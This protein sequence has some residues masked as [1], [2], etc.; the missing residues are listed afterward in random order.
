MDD[1]IAQYANYMTAERDR[2][3][4]TVERYQVVL[5]SFNRFLAAEIDPSTL[6]KANSEHVRGFIRQKAVEAEGLTPGSRNVAISALRSFYG[7][8]YREGRIEQDPSDRLERA[9][10][11]T[12]EVVPLSFNEY[13]AMLEAIEQKGQAAYRVRNLA[14]A[15]TLFHTGMRVAELVSLDLEDVDNGNYLFANVRVKG[16]NTL[17]M[18]YNDVVAEYIERWLR[19]RPYLHPKET[20]QA[21]FVSD[22]GTRITAQAVRAMIKKTAKVAGIARSITPHLLRHTT[23]TK[24]VELNVDL[25]VIQSK[26]GHASIRTTARYTHVEARQRRDAVDK[27]G[28]WYR[29]EKKKRGATGLSEKTG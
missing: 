23:A 21:L 16:G 1:V 12:Q 4:R 9:R 8:L 17:A 11:H 18:E 29:D 10:T 28:R 3:P 7:W 2:S 5:R 15:Q 14:I 19:S 13:L 6:S 26:L 22:R 24:L 25:P 20:E 27:L